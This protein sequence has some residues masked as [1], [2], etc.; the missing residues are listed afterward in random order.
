MSKDSL[1][2]ACLALQNDL[3][4]LTPNLLKRLLEENYSTEQQKI[5]MVSVNEAAEILDVCTQ[6]IY[7]MVRVKKLT[8]YPIGTGRSFKLNR[9]ELFNY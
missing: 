9:F 4:D 1:R 7:R 6:T 8:K 3:P 2:L 5:E